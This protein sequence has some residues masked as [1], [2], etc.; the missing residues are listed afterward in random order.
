MQ[1][2]IIIYIR[3]PA[4]AHWYTYTGININM[5]GNLK[6]ETRKT[7]KLEAQISIFQRYESQTSHF[8]LCKQAIYYIEMTGKRL[9]RNGISRE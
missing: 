6:S 8:G 9:Y 3:A 1:V 2:H 4:P 7:R 5:I